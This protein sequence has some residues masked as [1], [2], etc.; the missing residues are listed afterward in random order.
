MNPSRGSVAIVA[1]ASACALMLAGCSS[2]SSSSGAGKKSI[3]FIQGVTGDEFYITMQCSV[4]AQAKKEGATVTTQGPTKFDPTLQKPIVD[5]VVASKPSAILIAPTDAAAMQAPLKAAAAA[6]IKIVLVDTTLEDPSLAVSQISSD[7]AGGGAE[8]FRTIKQ[9]H[10]GGGKVL[11][12]STD[13]GITT[14]D[15]RVDGF[16]NAA[17]QDS[18]YRYLGVQYSHNEPAQAAKIITAAL[19][20]DPDIVGVFATATYA[21]EGVST[22]IQQAGKVNQVKVVGFD[23]GP[24]QVEQLRKGTVQALVAQDPGTI[25]SDGVQQAIAAID[26]R[27]TEAKISTGFHVITKDNIDGEGKQWIYKASC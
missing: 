24:Q 26:G 25:G 11:V 27:A 2:S 1:A 8:A 7:N 5:S 17:A 22:G 19:A 21:A 18:S 4:Q 16:K 20:K 6:G 23:A 15:A 12:V 9:L 13:P 14:A 3:T 10:P